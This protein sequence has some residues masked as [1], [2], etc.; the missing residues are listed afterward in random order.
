MKRK[1]LLLAAVV[2]ICG[3]PLLTKASE[4]K[5]TS[6]GIKSIGNIVYQSRAG[7]VELYA[8]D[9]ALLQEKLDSVPDEIFNP[10]LYSHMHSWEYIDITA[11]RHTK[12]CA[13]CGSSHDIIEMHQAAERK[14]CMIPYDDEEYIGYAKVCEC[15]YE[16]KEEMYHNLVY[17]PKDDETH[18]VS[19]ALSGTEYCNGMSP[20]EEEHSMILYAT[21]ESHHLASCSKCGFTGEE[22]CVF[23]EEITV[24]S[25]DETADPEVRKY[26]KCGNYITESSSGGEEPEPEEPDPE[27]PDPEEPDPDEGEDELKNPDPPDPSGTETGGAEGTENPEE[28]EERNTDDQTETES[29]GGML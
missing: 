8:E 14:T 13:G 15:G 27:K 17:D 26:C 4:T 19:C 18:T 5:A 11:K 2:F 16:W 12:H 7:S 24:D 25:D 28:T 1:A 29:E 23:E 9:I 6:S 21:D 20:M 3:I 22:E 10:V